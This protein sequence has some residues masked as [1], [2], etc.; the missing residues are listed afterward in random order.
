MSHP[1]LEIVGRLQDN[2]VMV[3][4]AFAR[5]PKIPPRAKALFL[6]LASHE[7]GW[8][9]SINA[10]CKATGMG[11]GTVYRA[12]N[13]LRVAGYVARQQLTDF[14]GRFTG[15]RYAILA[16]PLPEGE[17]DTVDDPTRLPED[18]VP[19]NRV[20]KS[21]KRCELGKQEKTTGGDRFPKNGIREKGIRKNGTLKKTN[22]KKTNGEENQVEEEG[23]ATAPTPPRQK[24]ATF[25]P[26]GWE[27][28]PDIARQMMGE[29]PN[30]DHRR[31]LE[32]FRDYWA[33]VGGQRGRKRDWDATWRNWIR[34]AADDYRHR[35][36]DGRSHDYEALARTLLDAPDV[37]EGEVIPNVVP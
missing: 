30:V 32:K 37:I 35:G 24:Q 21:G 1:M 14:T 5:D 9:L 22:N 3:S 31:E 28:R 33:G 11:R 13:D 18:G 4:N 27:P 16:V 17:R 12:I 6:Y 20:P 36:G 7:T 26:D 2:F 19:K 10:A 8:S 15:V 23:G 34:R 29:Y 25:L